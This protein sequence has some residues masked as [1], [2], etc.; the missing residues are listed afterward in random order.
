MNKNEFFI[1][2][3]SIILKLSLIVINLDFYIIIL[4]LSHQSFHFIYCQIH[5]KDK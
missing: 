3:Y 1:K 5:F 4:R 2:I